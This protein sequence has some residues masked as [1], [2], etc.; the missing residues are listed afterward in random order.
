M[1]ESKLGLTGWKLAGGLMGIKQ[2]LT[3]AYSQKRAREVAKIKDSSLDLR[4][5]SF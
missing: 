1:K 5:S 2:V 4:E 3:T